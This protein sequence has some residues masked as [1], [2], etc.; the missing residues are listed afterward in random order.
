MAGKELKK[1][2]RLGQTFNYSLGAVHACNRIK[3]LLPLIVDRTLS[4]IQLQKRDGPL[5]RP[6]SDHQAEFGRLDRTGDDV[7]LHPHKLSFRDLRFD[8]DP[9]PAIRVPLRGLHLPQSAFVAFENLHLVRNR[10][11]DID[12][13]RKVECH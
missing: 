3:K 2:L 12:D 13:D 8:V 4:L 5:T 10:N 9:E 11:L 6:R 1:S 7:L